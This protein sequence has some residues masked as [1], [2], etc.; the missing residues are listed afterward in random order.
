MQ[1][2]MIE[3][4]DDGSHLYEQIYSYIKDEIRKGK[5][6]Y[7]EKIPST[8]SLAQYLQV[9]RSTVELAYEQLLSEGYIESVPYKGYFAAKV[10]E[11]YRLDG[12]LPSGSGKS[13]QG[14]TASSADA[15]DAEKGSADADTCK[16]SDSGNVDFSP[17]AVDMRS[18]PFG[19]WRRINKNV[20]NQD[21]QELFLPGDPKGE[22]AL[23]ET[24]AR[25]LHASRGVSCSPEQIIVGAGNDYL[26]LLLRYI[27]GE[28]CCVAFENPTYP[29]ARRIFG[30]FSKEVISVPSDENGILVEKLEQG[31]ANVVYVMPSHQYPT[32][33]VMPIGRRAEL[34]NWAAKDRGRYVIEDDYDSEFRYRGKPIPSLQAS[35][36]AEKVIYIGTF[37]KSIAPAIRVSFLVLP[38]HL[39]ERYEERCGCFSSTV[40]RI[41]QAVLEEF[42]R[43]G[44]FERH[45]NRMRKV[46]SKKHEALLDGLKAFGKDFAV[47]GEN[48]GLHV[49]V[50]DRKGRSEAWLK[51]QA[52]QNGVRVYGLSEA[53]TEPDGCDLAATVLLGFGG[54]TEEEI[55]DGIKRLEKAWM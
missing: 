1:D 25:Y 7:Q 55:E 53:M 17:N 33:R 38:R 42:V 14:S 26:L 29:R 47:S 3:W 35:D 5:L 40:S 4:K 51:E 13:L 23:R 34:L 49:L 31:G 24:I 52:R 6:L 45:L 36:T 19:I 44:A 48:A 9:S 46:Y 37:S 28:D 50:T 21:N 20:L 2:L 32:G 30:L 8:R 16:A 11:L 15:E 54:L 18:F 41:D 39:M 22:P 43:S 10:E 12:M 27:L